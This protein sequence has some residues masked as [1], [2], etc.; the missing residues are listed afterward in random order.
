MCQK[1]SMNSQHRSHCLNKNDCFITQV[2]LKEE[3]KY[4]K[5]NIKALAKKDEFLKEKV[6]I[7]EK[8]KQTKE[9]ILRI[10]LHINVNRRI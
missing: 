9:N 4:N 6:Q 2:D 3:N 1:A 8:Y 10:G 7:Q 5:D